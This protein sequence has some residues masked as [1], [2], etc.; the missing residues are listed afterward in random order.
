MKS[1]LFTNQFRSRYGIQ[2]DRKKLGTNT[3]IKKIPDLFKFLLANQN[4]GKLQPEFPRL[5]P[6]F[7]PQKQKYQVQVFWILTDH[8]RVLLRNKKNAV[9]EKTQAVDYLT[10]KK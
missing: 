9:D 8:H 2:R 10:N 6:F 3:M 1:F 4:L 7:I 5:L